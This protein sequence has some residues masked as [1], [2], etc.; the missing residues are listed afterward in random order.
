MCVNLLEYMKM[1][2][3]KYEFFYAALR[4]L[5]FILVI[6]VSFIPVYNTS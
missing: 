1:A 6:K 5:P 4:L 2:E 3:V